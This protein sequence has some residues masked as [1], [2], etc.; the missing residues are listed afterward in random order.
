MTE[1]PIK[2]ETIIRTIILVLAIIN[3]ILTI[4]GKNPLPFTNEE[5]EEALTIIFTVIAALWAWWKNNSFTLPARI[6]DEEMN[7]Q[8]IQRRLYRQKGGRFDV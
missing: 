5:V 7:R 2:K 8:R 3:N 6:G 4:L 1:Y